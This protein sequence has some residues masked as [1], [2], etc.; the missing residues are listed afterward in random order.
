MKIFFK[1]YRIYMLVIM[2]KIINNDVMTSYHY[3]KLLNHNRFYLKL[4]FLKTCFV[5]SKQTSP[6]CLHNMRSSN[7]S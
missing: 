5:N 6:W 2:G 7:L 3:L 4:I 1:L